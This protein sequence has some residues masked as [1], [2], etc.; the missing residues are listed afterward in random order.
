MGM[1]EDVAFDP[2][3][4]AIEI[5]LIVARADEDVVVELNDRPRPI[6]AG[7]IKDV[8]VIAC[9]AVRHAEKVAAENA[10]AST[11]DAACAVQQFEIDAGSRGGEVAVLDNK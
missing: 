11:L 2:G 9:D 4:R 7:K 3:V 5:Q 8:V 1:E 10:V 6:P